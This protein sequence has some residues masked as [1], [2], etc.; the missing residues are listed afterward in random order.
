[1]TEQL[2]IQ[3]LTPAKIGTFGR[4]VLFEL[5]DLIA[6]EQRTTEG[7]Y[8]E[9]RRPF[10]AELDRLRDEHK[11]KINQLANLRTD[12]NRKLQELEQEAKKEQAEKDLEKMK[13]L[14]ELPKTIAEQHPVARAVLEEPQ[15]KQKVR[16]RKTLRW[17]ILD[18]TKIP[19]DY[20]QI[21]DQ[22]LREA[23]KAGVNVSGVRF[24]FDKVP[25]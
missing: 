6:K 4:E 5:R 2:T 11:P 25:Y 23:G 19:L 14:S 24:Y 1:M 3:N 12:V 20:L 8:K 22:K 13:R 16:I 18:R 15:V 7:I 21:D 17:T 9:L 10:Q